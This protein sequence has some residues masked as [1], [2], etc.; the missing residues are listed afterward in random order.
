MDENNSFLDKNTLIAIVLCVLFFVGWQNYVQRKYPEAYKPNKE[1]QVVAS[2]PGQVD[3]TAKVIEKVD[4]GEVPALKSKADIATQVKVLDIE[5]PN[6]SVQL[7]NLGMGI[8]QLQLSQYSD[9]NNQAIR[10]DGDFEGAGSLATFYLDQPLLFNV[11]KE[12]D[13]VFVGT[14]QAGSQ[15]IIKK[16]TFSPDNY[17]VDVSIRTLDGRPLTEDYLE[18]LITSRLVEGESM[19]FMPAYE[20][21]EFFTITD[22]SE[23]RER[24]DKDKSFKANYAKSS[25]LSIGS[26]Y[27]AVALRD[28]S[29][30]VPDARVMFNP[31]TQYAY[32]WL[33]HAGKTDGTKTNIEMT[34]FLGPKK[35]D[36]LKGINDD[37]SKMINYGIFSILSKPMLSMLKWLYSLFQNWGLAIILLTVFIRMILLPINLSSLKSMKKMQ[38]IQPQIKAI[39]EKYKDDPQRMNQE[40]MALMKR[41]KANPLGGCLPMLLQL[42]VFF[43]LYSVLGQSVELYKS[44]FIFWIQDLSYKDPFF[45]LPIAV[46]ALYFIQMQI[47]PQPMDP[48]QAKMMK[49][50]PIVFSFFMIAVPSGLTLYFFVN[51]IFGIGQQFLFQRE[52]QK[53]AA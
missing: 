13:L 14:A 53:A 34:A 24:L 51:T 28:D 17:S 40:T 47:T 21:T 43:A 16:M 48:A 8:Q 37:F 2:K 36:L 33:S 44:P 3:S 19:L 41:E 20:G 1:K 38:K 22:G 5:L 35:Y 15:T 46:G 23:S 18:T 9:R 11:T 26:Q 6:Y 7:S 25:L 30:I 31:D 50:I 29:Q 45:V 39:K 49:F 52:K 12:S 4:S 10:F 27:F 42:P 32:G